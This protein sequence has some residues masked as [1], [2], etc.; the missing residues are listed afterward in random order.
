M[1]QNKMETTL[2]T[3][4]DRIEVINF[5]KFSDEDNQL[6]ETYLAFETDVMKLSKLL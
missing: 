6:N 5:S 4:S 3:I 2:E 1:M